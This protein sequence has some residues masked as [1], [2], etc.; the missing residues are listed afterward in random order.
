D[1]YNAK[2]DY[3]KAKEYASKGLAL[4]EKEGDKDEIKSSY[5][6]LTNIYMASKDF[7]NAFNYQAKVLQLTD[8]LNNDA[9][10]KRIGQMQAMYE[11][12]KKQKEIELLTKDKEIQDERIARQN[13]IT[14]IVI[15]GLI[16]VLGLAF[17]SFKRYREKKKT[18]IELTAQ[19]G[20]IEEKNREILDSIHYAK[21]I[22]RA[23]LASDKL[24]TKKLS[25]YFILY[26]PKDIVSGDFYW[27]Q[28]TVDNRF[29]LATCDCT[30]HGVPGAFMS[31]LN[32]SKLNE[33]VIEKKIT[34]PDL[35]LN[36]VRDEIINALNSDI[37]EEAVTKDGMDAIL[38]SFDFNSNK[39]T[40]AAANNPLVIIRNKEILEYKADKFPVGVHH[41]ELKPFTLQTIDLQKGDCV[42]TITDGYADQFGG[43]KRKKL[44][45]KKLKEIL[46]SIADQSMEMQKKE[47]DQIFEKWRGQIEQVDDVLIIGIRV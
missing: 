23:L 29:L 6:T 45:S 28:S 38:C 11:A 40:F 32:I 10:N 4:V 34:Q 22:Q 3:K 39:M 9:I 35:I 18:N 26:K 33:T 47:L 42:Y 37:T 31:L 15:A 20:L 8:S 12:D 16:L 30:G 1:I 19:K 41:G 13:I 17:I 14:Y 25:E 27:A 44:M 5:L 43:D 2:G 7:E 36:Q 24:L 21:R 46:S